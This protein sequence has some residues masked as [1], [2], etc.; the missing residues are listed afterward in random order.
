MKYR[1]FVIAVCSSDVDDY[2]VTH[3]AIELRPS[4]IAR[5]ILVDRVSRLVRA[6][7][8]WLC[9]YQLEVSFQETTWLDLNPVDE[10]F[11]EAWDDGA[12][13]ES[14]DPALIDEYGLIGRSVKVTGDGW[15]MF[16]CCHKHSGTEY[17]SNEVAVRDLVRAVRLSDLA[18][19]LRRRFWKARP[20]RDTA[21]GERCS[22]D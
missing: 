12:I 18:A 10:D 4:V 14:I 3:V 9:F 15:L 8:G 16:S 17:T 1:L 22:A 11:P 13:E 5:L 19:E 2:S 20:A 6:A 7:I 21:G